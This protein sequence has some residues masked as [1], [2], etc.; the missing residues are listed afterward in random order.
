[1]GSGNFANVKLSNTI[2]A[3][4]RCGD[5]CRLINSKLVGTLYSSDQPIIMKIISLLAITLILRANV[6]AENSVPTET[7][8]RWVTKSSEYKAVCLQTYAAAWEKIE[9]VATN[10]TGPWAIVMDIDETVLSN[11]QYQI[12]LNAKKA[13]H[14]QEAWEAWVNR[15]EATPVPGTKA[16]ILKMRGLPIGR[17]IFLSSRF[18][19][20]VEATRRN[21]EQYG[22]TAK[23][24]VS[25]LRKNR[26]DTKAKRQ[27]EVAMSS[28]RMA[29]HG[30]VRVLAW[31]GDAA[32]D[33]PNNV[34][35]KWG[36]QKFMLPN[37]V[38]GSWE[39]PIF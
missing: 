26:E 5:E 37:P 18:L 8:I 15:I 12:E 4:D 23:N 21:L 32:H 2:D 6:L 28:G 10:A 29:S 14:S 20:N 34:K 38:Y 16:F 31:F 25:L 24:D 1:M 22:L 7:A 13:S 3:L 19:R 9:T 17:I 30:K 36:R 27:K 33:F 11:G 35:L 39:S